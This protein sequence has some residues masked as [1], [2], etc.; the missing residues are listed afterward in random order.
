M[1]CNRKLFT[2]LAHCLILQLDPAL[3]RVMV[4]YMTSCAPS[5]GTAFWNKWLMCFFNGTA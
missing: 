4:M 5:V 3:A 2:D 1:G